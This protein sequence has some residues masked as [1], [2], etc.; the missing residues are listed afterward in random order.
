MEFHEVGGAA[1]AHGGAGDDADDVAFADQAF[2]EEA[3]FGDDREAFDFLD[4][5]NG[6][7]SDAPDRGTCGGGFPLQEKKRRWEP[8]GR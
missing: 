7:G 4:V 1:D 2:F 5:G 3:L 6:A 8:R